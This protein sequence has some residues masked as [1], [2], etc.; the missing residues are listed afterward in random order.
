MSYSELTNLSHSL[1]RDCNRDCFEG[2]SV[3]WLLCFKF[4][5]PWLGLP[6]RVQFI[7]ILEHAGKP[8]HIWGK[9]TGENSE[10]S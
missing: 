3:V 9:T 8:T 5:S 10:F 6:V 1:S 7:A 4:D 2:A